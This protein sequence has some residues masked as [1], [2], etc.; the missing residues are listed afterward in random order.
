M[1]RNITHKLVDYL[2]FNVCSIN[3][4]G[5]YYGKAGI[6]LALFELSRQWRNDYWEEQAFE[7]LREALSTPTSD[8][9]F[10]NGLSGIGYTLLYLIDNKFVEADFKELFAE[11]T[12]N[13][14]RKLQHGHTSEPTV[15]DIADRIKTMYFIL[16]LRRH[17]ND[18][19]ICNLENSVT[20]AIEMRMNKLMSKNSAT[21][22]PTPIMDIME[23][24]LSLCHTYP[25]FKPH[26]SVIK[27]YTELY[28]SGKVVSD[29]TIG[30]YL[31]RM[32]KNTGNRIL[33]SVAENNITNA[34]NGLHAP[35][36]SLRQR[37]DMLHIMY[38]DKAR[39]GSAIGKLETRFT[40][41]D[42][43]S[44]AEKNLYAVMHGNDMS[45]G[46]RSGVARVLLCCAHRNSDG[47]SRIPLL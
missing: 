16:A 34:L 40:D 7:I 15:T 20:D 39:F 27:H 44:A 8:T 19:D 42:D 1:H 35:T 33:Q 18:C 22:D 12:N 6:A 2:L 30:Y 3:Q 46:Y 9:G 17:D 23:T 38:S 47:A 29:F 25:S 26:D 37:T 10:E 41:T 32:A 4:P 5:L 21:T 36:L 24:Y 14:K 11:N 13:I 43:E 31:E 45:A 28:N